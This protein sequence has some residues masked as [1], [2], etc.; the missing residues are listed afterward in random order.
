MKTNK[1]KLTT[2]NYEINEICY[3]F[4]SEDTGFSQP[5]LPYSIIIEDV[6]QE[7]AENGIELEDYLANAISDHT[8]FCVECFNFK[9][10]K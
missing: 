1:T 3:D 5:R 2:V 10:I 4:G 6:P 8:G 9:P 7:I